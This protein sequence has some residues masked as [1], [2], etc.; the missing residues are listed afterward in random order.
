LPRARVLADAVRQHDDFD[1][2]ECLAREQD[3][4][5]VAEILVVDARCDAVPANNRHGIGF[6]ERLALGISKNTLLPIEVSALRKD[7][8]RLMHQNQTP[9][10]TAASLCLYY[11]PARAVRRTWTPQ[12]FLRRIQFW[13]EKA[14]RDEL[15]AAD[16]PAEQLFFVTPYELVLPWNFEQLR[17]TRDVHFHVVAG[18]ERPGT[19]RTYFLHASV[20]KG[21]PQGAVTPFVL[22]LAPVLHGRVETDPRT[23]GGLAD[24][25]DARGENLLTA[26]SEAIQAEVCEA[27]VDAN[28]GGSFSVLL[29]EMPVTKEPGG[30][31][32]RV[33]RRAFL[34]LRGPFELGVACG[35]LL[36]QGDRYFRELL[37]GLLAAPPK[38]EWRAF[39]SLAMEVQQGIDRPAARRQSGIAGVGPNGVVIGAGALGSAVLDLW[40]RCGWGE[41]TV[42]DN[43][44]I[45]PHNLVRH[46]A[47]SGQVGLS[48]A[49][50]L[51]GLHDAVMRG[52]GSMSAIHADACDLGADV[53]TALQA[54]ALAIDASTTLDYPRLASSRNDVARHASIFVT[55]DANGAVLLMEDAARV[56]QLRT[57]EA[58]YYRALL[59][60]D[61]GA[62]HLA[63][64]LGRYWSGA[65]C[66]D[67]SYV[68]PY[69]RIVAHAALLAEQVQTASEGP[70]AVI[71]I[72]ARDPA[73]GTVAMREVPAATERSL[74]LGD[75]TLYIDRSLEDKLRAMRSAGLPSE[76]GGILLGYHDF[77]IQ[78]VVVVDALPAPPDSRSTTGSFERGIE[79]VIEPPRIL[80]RL[81]RLRM[82]PT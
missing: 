25:L 16:Q 49:H 58:Q 63:H 77:N 41:W 65:S 81:L 21:R 14:S 42:I 23:L 19:G 4:D 66:R 54:A 10:G 36:K 48:K 5:V 37:T 61:W 51:V 60:N 71:R 38:T 45:K 2:V 79:G 7:F 82:E 17:Q 8:P 1:L 12:S 55:P 73:A 13:L 76:T 28:A 72:W 30:A 68:M 6:P 80:R 9:E 40:T 56:Q 69:S 34:L 33:F 15:H 57:L 29:L 52:A 53:L 44:H 27:G 75:L 74:Q 59:T 64:H 50:A 22:R 62:S 78:A 24:L 3:G 18:P 20:Q 47:R 70:D 39:E 43:D 67:I 26:L 31:I 32:D 11:E 35:A 46:V